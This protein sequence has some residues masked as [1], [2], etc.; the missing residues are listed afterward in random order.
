M[1]RST[2]LAAVLAGAAAA[3]FFAG[4]QGRA[5]LPAQIDVVGITD[6]RVTGGVDPDPKAR[7]GLGPGV[8]HAQFQ[9]QGLPGRG[10]I[11]GVR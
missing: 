2:L 1:R 7:T 6:A 10:R 3:M 4:I 9:V 8:L 5:R 11:H